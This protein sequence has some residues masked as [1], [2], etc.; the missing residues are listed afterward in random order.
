MACTV[1]V[2]TEIGAHYNAQVRELLEHM[3]EQKELLDVLTRF[4]DDELHHLDSALEEGA[5]KAPGYETM[6]AV[7][8]A[9]TRAAVWVAERV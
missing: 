3:P 2:E 1:A 8:R 5:E 4:R 7:I 6:V 9:G